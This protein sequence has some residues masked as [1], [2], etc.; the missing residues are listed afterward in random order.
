MHYY[1]HHIG[2]YN[3]DTA[4]LSLAE[5]G[6]YRLLM[7]CYYVTGEALP[8]NQATLCRIVR[9]VSKVERDAVQ[10]VS[11]AFFLPTPEGLRHKRIDAEILSYKN[12]IETASRAGKASAESRQ[13]KRNDRSTTVDVPLQRKRNDPTNGMG[14]GTST[15]RQ[16]T[17]NHK[18]ITNMIPSVSTPLTPLPDGEGFTYSASFLEFWNAYPKREGKGAASQSWNRVKA[19]PKID[20]LLAA[21]TRAKSSEQWQKNNG[22]FIPQPATWLNQRRWEDEGTP[23]Q[24]QPTTEEIQASW[25]H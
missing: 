24:N 21:L 14:N 16:P 9:A 8:S 20:V 17:I 4:H 6:A 15:E 23:A 11:S 7:D 3:R 2:D 5:H 12:Q 19:R 10:K 1:S 22:Q 25:R 13:R 18:P